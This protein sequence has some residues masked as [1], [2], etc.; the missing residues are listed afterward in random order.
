MRNPPIDDDQSK[1]LAAPNFL[2][3]YTPYKKYIVTLGN[4]LMRDGLFVGLAIGSLG[5][6]CSAGAQ[7]SGSS[8]TPAG[9]ID[10]A[11]GTELGEI[12]VTALKRSQSVQD[13]A[14]TVTVV[15]G[16]TLRRQNITTALALPSV[17][18]GL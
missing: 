9:S 13:V 16:D 4:M 15:T 12:I 17:A 14:A 6:A 3:Y 11:A 18:P 10:S 7:T 1:M 8:A 2:D 5:I